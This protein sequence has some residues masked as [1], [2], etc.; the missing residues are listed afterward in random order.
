M[1]QSK[2]S[3]LK[4]DINGTKVLRKLMTKAKKIKI[5]YITKH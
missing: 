2:L 5:T 1:K 4:I 3:S